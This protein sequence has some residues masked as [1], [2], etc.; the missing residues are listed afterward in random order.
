MLHATVNKPR[1]GTGY[2][3]EEKKKRAAARSTLN[4]AIK[5]G[6]MT[7]GR[8]ETC[9]EIA[10]AHHDD[11]DRPLKVR[12]FCQHHHDLHHKYVVGFSL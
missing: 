10:E 4:N 12:W 2:S 9:S 11:Y 1:L 6:K 8:C 7:R 5:L 3:L